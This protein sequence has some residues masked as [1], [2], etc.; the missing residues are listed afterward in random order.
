M[1][2]AEGSLGE[3]KPD[4]FY[5]AAPLEPRLIYQGEIL[6]DVPLFVMPFD[7][8]GS[9]WL[10]LRYKGR[11]L[12]EALR[13]GQTPKYIEVFDSNK[14][15][16]EWNDASLRGDCAVGYL[17]KNPVLVLSQTCDVDTK[18]FIQVAP[19]YPTKDGNYIGKLVRNDIISAFW[20]PPHLPE[21]DV[22]MYA[23]FEHIQAVHK[24]YRKKPAPHFRLSPPRLLELQRSITR[25]F[26]RPNS[27]DV[28]RDLAP[29]SATY[30]CVQCFHRDGVVTSLKLIESEQFTK[31]SVCQGSG[32]TIQLGSME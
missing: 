32:W 22:D 30:L 23:D 14:S 24:S 5:D 11:P 26:G 20:V 1:S 13:N 4:E 10:L 16:I 28:D 17:A 25:Y 19:I 3:V 15:D 27:F 21:W 7:T 2:S 12:H 31:C 9:R 29:R 8:L 6:L 18:K